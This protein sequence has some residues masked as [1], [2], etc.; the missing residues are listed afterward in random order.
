VPHVHVSYFGACSVDFLV[1]DQEK[2]YL[3]E[4]PTGRH[5]VVWRLKSGKFMRMWFFC[6]WGFVGKS[7]AIY[8]C[9]PG[10]SC[11]NDFRSEA[12]VSGA[13]ELHNKV[14]FLSQFEDH[15]MLCYKDASSRNFFAS[16]W[17]EHYT[18]QQPSGQPS[19]YSAAAV[20]TWNLAFHCL[21]FPNSC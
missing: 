4:V 3:L 14:I 17:T 16:I 2:C 13:R 19:S 6:K 20:R 12:H 7:A 10:M 1:W 11:W 21:L 15:K 5:L 18:A 9:Y 8:P